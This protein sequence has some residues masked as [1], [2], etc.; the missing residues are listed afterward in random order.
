MDVIFCTIDNS[1]PPLDEEKRLQENGRE[2]NAAR[3]SLVLVLILRNAL[4]ESAPVRLQPKP[5]I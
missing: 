4:P 1:L 3:R 2:E 5:L